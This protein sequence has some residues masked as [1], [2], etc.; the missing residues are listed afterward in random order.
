MTR[1]TGL[2]DLDTSRLF[3][4]KIIALL[5]RRE[6]VG[7]ASEALSILIK[8]LGAAGGSLFYAARPPIRI[9]RGDL[10]ATIAVHLTQWEQSVE[11]RI[12]SGSWKMEKHAETLPVCVSVPGSQQT[13]I[14]GLLFDGAEVTG[15]V[16]L[17]FATGQ[18]PGNDLRQLLP[19]FLQIVGVLM[20]QAG[21]L[22]LTKARLSQLSLFYQVAQ[23]MASTFDLVKVLENTMQLASAVLDASASALM[24]VDE[25]S[26]E[27]VFE[28]THG[29][30]GAVLRKQRTP[31]DEGLAGWVA[32]H[33]APVL[34]N[35]V[36]ADPRFSPAV[37]TRTGFLTQSVVCVPLQIRGKTIGV[38]EA[39]NKRGGH[40][41]DSEDL[42]L[43][44]T[45]ANQASIAI[46]NARLYQNIREERDRIIQAQEDVRRQ[47]AR[48]LHDG[49]IQFLSA[50][51]MGIDHL[52]RLLDFRPEAARSHLD[53]LRDLTRQATQQ[54]R[55][56]LFELRPLILETRGL[57][58]A[59]E[60]YV[61]QLQESEPFQIHFEHPETLPVIGSA[62]ARTIFAIIQE[63]VNNA[64]KHA[65]P[66]DVWLRLSANGGW[67]Q[68]TIQDNGKGFDLEAVTRDYDR[69]GSIGMLSMRERAELIDGLLDI[70]SRTGPPAPG[71][72][73]TL[74]VPL[75]E[76]SAKAEAE[77]KAQDNH[78]TG[79]AG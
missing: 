58:P 19:S 7:V 13:V 56:A 64:K 37:D 59:L 28:Y 79:Q 43:M 66:R 10:P 62:V 35:D 2:P 76:E 65:S 9:R 55:L 25:E 72:Q 78:D 48:N 38:L 12:L 71:T 69:K 52:E 54:A 24:L 30:L 46:E 42:G 3:L 39:L 50:I 20:S 60:A 51:T 75:A 36:R 27:L 23:S 22:S 53:A 41:F 11:R 16:S 61:D 57:V 17:V 77:G 44:I 47:V 1:Q 67:L 73:I 70:Q 45:T 4:D 34:V 29:P 5:A 14:Y 18:A 8:D 6:P 31:L 15:A 49:T 40:G 32:T 68:V 74:R 26:K 63:A 33:G 21:E